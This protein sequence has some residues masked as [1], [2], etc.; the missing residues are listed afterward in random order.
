M[1]K[2]RLLTAVFVLSSLAANAQTMHF[3]SMFDTN[4]QKI[5]SGMKTE[6]MLINNELQ[7]IA[8]YLEEFG[9]DSQ[10]SDYYGVN[11]GRSSLIQAINGLQVGNNDVVVFYYGGHG[12]RAVSDSDRFPQMCL[13]ERNQANW[14][15]SSLIKNMITKK[16]PR[17]TIVLTGC[18]NYPDNGVT[19]K[20]IIAQS[21]SYTSMANINKEAFKE[22]FLNSKGVVQLTSSR[23]GEFSWCNDKGSF[24]ALAL[25]E[26]LNDVGKGTV[27]PN[28]NS[29]CQT[30]KG[31][32]SSLNIPT[33]EGYVKQNP[34]YEVTTGTG[35]P[36]PRKDDTTI[37]RRVN[38]TNYDLAQDL[39]LLLDKSQN[40]NTR[41]GMIPGILSK[42]FA[43]GAKV[44][45]L[46]RDMN[47]VV[48]Y[49]DAEVFLRRVAMSPYI[50]QINVVE[51][52]GGKNTIIRVH[53]IRTR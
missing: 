46:G 3:I 25:L 1:K 43:N 21:G 28:W 53:E 50:K 10:F 5:G 39:E 13:G 27:S 33:Q 29:V 16:N 51:Q 11:C 6:R 24:F 41:L 4:D 20:S 44:L 26:T 45:T 34:D 36:P 48:D 12:A 49:E 32:V 40:A 35:G 17:L 38:D 2:T 31:M 14:V 22:L 37:K 19:I 23:A 18:C 42:H 7:T 8:G 47:T 9:Y 52:N 15:P 30:I